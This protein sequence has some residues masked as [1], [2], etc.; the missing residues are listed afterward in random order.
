MGKLSTTPDTMAV[1]VLREN[2][3]ITT[4]V[5]AALYLTLYLKVRYMRYILLN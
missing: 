5:A 3:V 4:I 1:L 2:G